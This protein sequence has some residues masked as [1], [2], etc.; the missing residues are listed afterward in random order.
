MQFKGEHASIVLTF[1]VLSAVTACAPITPTPAAATRTPEVV[2]TSTAAAPTATL[3]PTATPEPAGIV[4]TYILPDVPLGKFQNAM[5]PGSITNDRK[6]MLGS[7]GSDLWHGAAD[8]PDQ[9]W[10][11]T[12]RG[13][14]QQIQVRALNQERRTFPVPEFN[15]AIVHVQIEGG[16]IRILESIPILT[17]S[18][19][20]VTGLPNLVGYDEDGFDY[21]AQTKIGVN[22]NGLDTEGLARAVGGDFWVAEEYSP[23][24]LHLDKTGNV[25]MR[26]IP[27]GLDLKGTDYPVTPALPGILKK[28]KGNRG[29][30]GMGMSESEKLLYLVVQSP[31]RNPDKKTGDTSR[32]TRIFVFD[33]ASEKVV[34]EYAYLFDVSTEFDPKVNPPPTE[35]KISAIVSVLPTKL[36]VQERTDEL[37]KLYLVDT[38]L[39]TNLIGT[40]WDNEATSPSLEALAVKDLVASGVNVLPKT[41]VMDFTGM[42]EIP[43]KIEGVAVLDRNTI[44]IANDNEF[45]NLGFDETGNNM[46][47][48][49]KNKIIFIRLP[50]PLF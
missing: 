48:G 45:D 49:M 24:V 3:V 31:M 4:A 29:F 17:A 38:S 10:M 11:V 35:M 18:G 19:K 28:R 41:L 42:E 22:P 34:A 33:V 6:L 13:P 12:D 39:A 43:P 37:M 30:D 46:V 9:F 44:A 27:E 8:P 7:I 14:N 1:I 36:L 23:S 32:I 16:A 47:L 15:P 40:K 26:Y 21:L 20:P 50:K 2:A 25:L 5:L